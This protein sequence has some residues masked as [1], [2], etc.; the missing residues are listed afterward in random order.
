[1]LVLFDVDGTLVDAGGAG[2]E[3][4]CKAF[5]RVFGLS[6][7]GRSAAAVPFDGRTDSWI[8]GE[9]A[10]GAGVDPAR[11][12]AHREALEVAYL[13]ILEE[14]L[15]GGK[16]A[17]ALP[18]VSALL[19]ALSDG[20]SPVGLVTGNIR[21]GAQVKLAAAGIDR[22]FEEGAFGDDSADRVE[23]ARLARERFERRMGV[24][25]LPSSVLL[26]GDS[27]QDVRA[28]RANGYRC[29]AVATG[30]TRREDLRAEGPDAVMEDLSAT[31]DVLGWIGRGG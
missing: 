4:L 25:F 22:Y 19:E 11:L 9:I 5:E 29:L 26:V 18:G 7:V 21:R 31:G 12:E 28:A 20:G 6:G 16:R 17:R 27:K 2:R 15:A 8:I 10:A 24:A 1:M 23:L 3:S 14:T 13:G 30:W